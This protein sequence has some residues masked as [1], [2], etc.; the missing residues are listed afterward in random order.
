MK[1]IKEA[2]ALFDSSDTRSFNE[3]YSGKEDLFEGV[4]DMI[5][6]RMRKLFEETY[7]ISST[8]THLKE[9]DHNFSG[10]EPGPS[11]DGVPAGHNRPGLE[12]EDHEAVQGQGRGHS[13]NS[14]I[15]ESLYNKSN[16]NLKRK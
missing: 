9:A 10:D 6:P 15:F 16:K 13:D 4:D 1:R 12:G 2:Y 8:K 11:D 14:K 5:D 7:Q 3:I